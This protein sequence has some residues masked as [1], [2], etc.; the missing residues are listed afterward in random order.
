MKDIQ[1]LNKKI[2]K[3]IPIFFAVD[4]NYATFLAVALKSIQQNSSRNYFY[5]VFVLNAGLKEETMVKLSDMQDENYEINFVN[6]QKELAKIGGV[7]HTRDYYTKSTYYRLFI[8]KLFPQFDKALYLDSDIVVLG[9]I[10]QLYNQDLKNNLV[11][12]VIEDVMQNVDVFGTYVEECLDIDRKQYFNA[13]ILLMNLKLFRDENVEGQFLNLISRFKFAVTQD[14]DYLNVIC[15][16]RVKYFD[17]AWNK[18]PMQDDTFDDSKVK[19]VHYKMNLKPW[20][21]DNI[22]YEN[23][24][25][26]YASQTDFIEEIQSIKQNYSQENKLKD[27]IS[28]NNLVNLAL[29]EIAREDSYK[30]VMQKRKSELRFTGKDGVLWQ[31]LSKTNLG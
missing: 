20:H 9:D 10:S 8:Q 6:V 4:D 28:Y 31:M 22:K 16:Q 13:G 25:W 11:G 29:S 21:Y 24:F 1:Q 19:L 14:E 15:K 2:L 17:L 3:N 12:A 23:Y 30:K 26:E 27:E 18:S 5:S 7:L